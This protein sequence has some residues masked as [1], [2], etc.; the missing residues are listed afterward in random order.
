MQYGYVTFQNV[1]PILHPVICSEINT[2]SLQ[3]KGYCKRKGVV[4]AVFWKLLLFIVK[5]Y[6]NLLYIVYVVFHAF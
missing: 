6:Y 1:A 2:A 4:I 5:R 3:T